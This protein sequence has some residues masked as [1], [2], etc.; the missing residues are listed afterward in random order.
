[1]SYVR[2]SSDNFRSDVYM[3]GGN[4]AIYLHVARQRHDI[5]Y[6]K[7]PEPI[8]LTAD[9]DDTLLKAWHEAYVVFN[10]MLNE[11]EMVPIGLPHD[12]ETFVFEY[13]TDPDEDESVVAEAEKEAFVKLREL[14]AMGYHVPEWVFD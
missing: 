6:D 7:V 13:D 9:M 10:G 1:M 5:D 11:A 2:F 12:G 4:D 3:Y 8:L 14:Q